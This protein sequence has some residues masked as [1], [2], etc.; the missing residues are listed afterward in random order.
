[1]IPLAFAV[2]ARALRLA[3]SVRLTA[4][5]WAGLALKSVMKRLYAGGSSIDKGLATRHAQYRSSLY[6]ATT[7]FH[8]GWDL[9]SKPQTSPT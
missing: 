1:M 5:G 2:R 9:S 8:F 4:A 3:G 6:T 7:H